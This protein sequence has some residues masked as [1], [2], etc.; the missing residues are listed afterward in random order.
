MI[1]VSLENGLTFSFGTKLALM[2]RQRTIITR[3]CV[4]EEGA[5]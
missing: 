5:Q 4:D 3:R 1:D 2:K